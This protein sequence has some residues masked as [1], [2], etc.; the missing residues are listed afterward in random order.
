MKEENPNA[1][2]N[3]INPQVIALMG[4]AFQ[5]VYPAFNVKRFEKLHSQL[6]PLELKARV[7]LLKDGL[8]QELPANYPQ[9]MK[10]IQSVI[11]NGKL[12][13]FQLW[14]ISEYI[15]QYG[16]DHFKLSFAAMI[17]LTKVF[18]SEFA[19]RP[20]L[21]KDHEQC[22]KLLLP[23]AS[24]K[25]AHVRRWIS[26]GSR[27]ILP[28]GGKIPAFIKEP[29]LTLPLLEKLKYDGE[30]YVRKSVANHLNDISKN[31]PDLVV[32][33]LKKW[34]K[35]T[36][37][38]HAEKIQWITRHALRVLIKKGH[39]GAL[40]LMGAGENCD[41]KFQ[42]FKL[43]EKKYRTDEVLEFEI[44]FNST[45]KKSQKLIVDYVID[46]VKA[47][48]KHSPKVFKLKTLEIAPGEKIVLSKKHSL[49]KITT[50]TFFNGEHFLSIQINGKILKK[51]SWHFQP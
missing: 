43:S 39:T 42:H 32:K 44:A 46:F 14:P 18:T 17:D 22:L 37:V 51:A 25:N 21:L 1:F 38:E 2:K 49:K 29:A 50:M 16:L 23:L 47:N 28:W 24:D 19:I 11:K 40:K 13:G 36:P 35:E 7:L 4:E 27:P 30:L 20:F 41:L 6:S 12:S 31:H 15:S 33:L 10:I 3:F 45:S 48:G 26:E 5:E 34:N 8:A 9:A